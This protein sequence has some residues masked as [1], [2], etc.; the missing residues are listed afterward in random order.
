MRAF[1]VDRETAIVASGIALEETDTGPGER[2]DLARRT[3][4]ADHGPE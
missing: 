3:I 1:S 4:V 2:M